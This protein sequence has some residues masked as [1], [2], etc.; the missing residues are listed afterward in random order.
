[1]GGVLVDVQR[2]RAIRNFQSIGLSDA[3]TLIDSYHHKGIFYDFEKGVIDTAEFCRLLS[4]IY[5]QIH[6]E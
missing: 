1:M 2:D 6:P 3:D 5:R 4:E